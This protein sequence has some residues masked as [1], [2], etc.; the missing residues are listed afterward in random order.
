LRVGYTL[1]GERGAGSGKAQPGARASP[2]HTTDRLL[3][4][5]EPSIP[6]EAQGALGDANPLKPATAEAAQRSANTTSFLAPGPGLTAAPCARSGAGSGDAPDPAVG[7][8]AGGAEVELRP[9]GR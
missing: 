8:V 6:C 7:S 9:V 3:S 1:A 2:E 4:F 5:R